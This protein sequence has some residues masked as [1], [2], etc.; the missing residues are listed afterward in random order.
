M[1]ALALRDNSAATIVGES[2]AGMLFG[3]DGAELTGGQTII[4]R[5]EPTLL[6]P[7]GHDYS[8]GGI[9]PDARVRDERSNEHDAILVRALELARGK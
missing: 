7:A 5:S 9:L 4:F 6:S 8:L 1:L 2:T 3:K